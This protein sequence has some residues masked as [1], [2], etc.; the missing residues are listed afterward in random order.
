[1]KKI[2][3]IS[4]LVVFLA[5]YTEIGQLLKLPVLLHHYLEHHENDAATTF[6]DFLHHHYNEENSHPSHNN[7]HSKLP[8]KS[9]NMGVSQ[10]SFAYLPVVFESRKDIVF[11]VKQQPAFFNISFNVSSHL[12]KIWQPPKSC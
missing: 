8:F 12:S 9:Q 6:A 10:G 11:T 1:L 2:T 4:L 3:A 7:E 5:A